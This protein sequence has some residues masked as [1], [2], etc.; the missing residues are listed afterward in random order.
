MLGLYYLSLAKEGEPG[1]GKL[2]VDIGEIEAALDAGVVTLHTKI[3][4]RFS[5]MNAEGVRRARR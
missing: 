2:F 4:A 3:K 1:E 5:E